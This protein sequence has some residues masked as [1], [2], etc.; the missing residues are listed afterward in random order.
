MG[1]FS[2][3]PNANKI[4]D[5]AL[6]DYKAS[7]FEECYKKVC[8]ACELGSARAYFCK[9]L[10]IYNDNISPDSVPDFEV[11]KDL[12]KKAVE[13]GYT[14]AY[15][16]YA[17][18]LHALGNTD[19]LC[20]F[21]AKKCKVHD[22]LYL[23]FKASYFFGLYTDD[24]MGSKKDTLLAIEEAIE[25]LKNLSI[26]IENGKDTEGEER[27]LYNPYT[28]F[29][30]RYCYAHAQYV[31][32]TIYYCEDDWSTRRSF[33]TSFDEIMKYMPLPKEKYNATSQYMKAIL[34]NCLGMSDFNE[35]NR[36]MGILND[37]F[38]ALSEDERKNVLE[39]YNEIYSAYDE[40][41]DSE[42]ESLR[43]RDVTY[44]DGYADK[45]DISLASVASAIT[46]G[47]KNWSNSSSAGT[48]TVYT[49]GGKR[50]TRGELGYLYDEDNFKSDYRV[51][52]YSRLYNESNTELGYFN[53]DGLFIDN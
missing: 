53:N 28:K 27:S 8:D 52:D 43:N 42:S 13:G 37:C 24:V 40:F 4:L 7:R 2:K 17:Y 15:G 10:L 39:E 41:Y 46:D 29:S 20:E 14:F 1:L 5:E 38:N 23:S 47:A 25:S 26:S 16:F 32:L 19:E 11:L 48:K 3:K 34:E 44:S 18:V 9:A 21:L 51:D 6:C 36:A 31:L 35:A 45:N 49:I 12:A 33:M 50:Y 22:G 30:V